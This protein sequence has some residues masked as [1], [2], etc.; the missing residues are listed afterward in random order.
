MY[1]TRVIITLVSV[2]V[3]NSYWPGEARA[4]S[5]TFNKCCPKDKLVDEEELVCIPAAAEPSMESTDEWLPKG[6]I[7]G[8]RGQHTA[9]GRLISSVPFHQVNKFIREVKSHDNDSVLKQ[10]ISPFIDNLAW[11]NCQVRCSMSGNSRTAMVTYYTTRL[12]RYNARYLME[13]LCSYDMK[14]AVFWDETY[15]EKPPFRISSGMGD[16]IIQEDGRDKSYPSE[17]YC[18][19]RA[20]VNNS[21]IVIYCP[22]FKKACLLKCCPKGQFLNMNTSRCHSNIPGLVDYKLVFYDQRLRPLPADKEPNYYY[23]HR[24]PFCTQVGRSLLNPYDTSSW[25]HFFMQRDGSLILVDNLTATVVNC[26][27]HFQE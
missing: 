17:S 2:S 21:H 25:A 6:A 9:M 27:I 22:C 12:S 10:Q 7:V 5:V 8:S 3:L 26:A 4:P 20:S 18:A 1:R 15:E 14:R 19:D 24:L 11:H 16:L 23:F 13:E